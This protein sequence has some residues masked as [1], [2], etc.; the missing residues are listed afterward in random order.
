VDPLAVVGDGDP[1]G[2]AAAD[3]AEQVLETAWG[4]DLETVVRQEADGDRGG[5]LRPGR[6]PVGG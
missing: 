2:V 6:D 1:A 3:E 5:G 4:D